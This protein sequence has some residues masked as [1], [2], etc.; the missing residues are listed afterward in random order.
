MDRVALVTGGNRGIGLA[1]CRGMARLGYTVLL[2]SRDPKKGADAA[3]EL[4][5]DGKVVVCPLDV[6]SAESIAAA[7]AEIEAQYGRIDALI[8]NAAILIDDDVSILDVPVETFLQTQQ[9]NL[10]GTLM[11]CQAFMPMMIRQNYGRVV[12]LSS[13]MGQ[14]SSPIGHRTAAYSISKVAINALTRALAD[15]VRRYNIKV[16]AVDPGW[17][18]TDMSPDANRSPD[19]GAETA[20]WLA[21]L[22]EDGPTDGFFYDLLPVDW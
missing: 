19:E 11:M 20:I 5:L 12:N 21:T 16:N 10:V 3:A 18:R 22:P 8:N 7:K 1:I 14:I 9:T 2:G 13:G 6:S 17:V 4:R 15:S